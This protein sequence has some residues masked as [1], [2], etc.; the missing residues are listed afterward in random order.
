[1]LRKRLLSTRIRRPHGWSFVTDVSADLPACLLGGRQFL[2]TFRGALL[3]PPKISSAIPKIKQP[4]PKLRQK[5][6]YPTNGG[7]KS[8]RNVGNKLPSNT[9]TLKTSSRMNL[10]K[11][12][13]V[14]TQPKSATVQSISLAD[15]PSRSLDA[16]N[17]PHM[18]H[19][20]CRPTLH[21]FSVLWNTRDARRV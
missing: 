21:T 9:Q 14:K 8:N 2:S 6:N 7:N 11:T 16:A 20:M 15:I 10:R 13:I 1:M 5:I 3:S 18:P 12:E 17:N 4:P 19:C